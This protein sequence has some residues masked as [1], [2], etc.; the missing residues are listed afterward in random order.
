M[1]LSDLMLCVSTVKIDRYIDMRVLMS[2]CHSSTCIGLRLKN[3]A[4]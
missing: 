3:E 4:T 2:S 1:H